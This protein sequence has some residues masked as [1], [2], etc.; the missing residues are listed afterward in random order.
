VADVSGVLRATREQS[1][2]TLEEISA[3][4]RIKVT[5]LQAI[6]R[7]DFDQLPGDFFARAF[8][9]T[10]ARELHLSPDDIV[11]EYDV[12]RQ[13]VDPARPRPAAPAMPSEGEVQ[14]ERELSDRALRA[15]APSRWTTWAMAPAAVILLVTVFLLMQPGG[16][17]PAE[18]RA[19]GTTGQIEAAPP[20][21]VEPAPAPTVPK[22]APGVV[23]VAAEPETLLVDLRATGT[24]WITAYA[25]GQRVVYRLFRAGDEV[26]VEGAELSFRVGNAGAVDYSINGA[27]AMAVGGRGD[28]RE[29][30]ITRD[31]YQGLLKRS[32]N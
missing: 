21:P 30:R 23:K 19:V 18:S 22:A 4:T 26:T 9:R 13:T 15:V 5:F 10:Y 1:G 11:R 27:P 3:R 17:G 32:E 6:E 24:T 8:L 31:N 16:E 25:D 28:V 14:H 29:F 2:L 12:S 20:A 7:G